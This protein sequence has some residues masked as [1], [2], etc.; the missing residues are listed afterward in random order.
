[1]PMSEDDLLRAVIQMARL[2]GVTTAHFRPAQAKNGNWITAV[3]GDGKGYPD[4][5]LVG[6]N[7]V[8]W[9]ELKSAKGAISPEQVVWGATL[10]EAGQDF[11]V[12]RPAD[13]TSGRI[14]RELRDL[15][16]RKPSRKLPAKQD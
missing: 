13:L 16:G 10:A 1:M 4:L 15:A 5:T 3:A 6:R 14:E 8:M 11:A 2:F 9:R 7:G 12:W